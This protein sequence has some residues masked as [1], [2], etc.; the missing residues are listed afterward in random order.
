MGAE[1]FPVQTT[2]SEKKVT[3]NYRGDGLGGGA[4][5]LFHVLFLD[6]TCNCMI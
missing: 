2:G 6:S 5:C 3:D 1:C 4:V